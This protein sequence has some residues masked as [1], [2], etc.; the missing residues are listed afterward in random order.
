MLQSVAAG[1]GLHGS[2][3]TCRLTVFGEASRL[4]ALGKT[5]AAGIGHWVELSAGPEP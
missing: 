1:T 5:N 3:E 2:I 4:L